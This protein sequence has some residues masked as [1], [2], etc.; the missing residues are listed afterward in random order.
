MANKKAKITFAILMVIIVI[1]GLMGF[2]IAYIPSR[3]SEKHTNDIVEL[4]FQ[5]T[6]YAMD[7]FNNRWG[8]ATWE[9]EIESNLG[10]TIPVYY[11]LSDNNYE[12]KTVVLVHWHESNHTAMY[13]IAQV[14][15]EK[16][17]NVVLYD[18]RAHGKNTAHTVTFGYLESQDLTQV[19][20]LV[21][22]KI[23]DKALGVL[24]Q[25][26]GASTIAYYLGS[27][28]AKEKLTFAVMDSPYSGMY[29]EIAWEIS[30][31]KIPIMANG[32]TSVGS[33]WCEILYGY[34]FKIVDHVKQI[35]QSD[36]P[37]LIFH[38]KIDQ[39]C[40][41]Y[42]AEDIFEAIPHKDKKLVSYENSEHLFSFWDEQ[43]RYVDE[44]FSFI[45]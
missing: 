26:M 1:I 2:L 42:M 39:K 9:F 7:T 45:E 27:E 20:S 16:G 36:T 28:D 41:Y 35:K 38:S 34:D 43:E 24:G 10:H 3:M 18:Q 13:P 40:P 12:N 8:S 19:I 14:F 29:A 30:K 11:I 23:G 17:W 6:G 25:S 5:D 31:G 15:L 33:I 4:Y 22:E 37:T 21:K 32:L 44:L